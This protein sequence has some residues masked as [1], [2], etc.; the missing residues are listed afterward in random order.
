MSN[1]RNTAKDDFAPMMQK[2][3]NK[4]S[5]ANNGKLPDDLSLLGSYFDPPVDD[6]LLRRYEP[7]DKKSQE[8]SNGVAVIEKMVV[9]PVREGRV[10]IGLHYTSVGSPPAQPK[11]FH[12]PPEL[13]PALKLYQ[14]ENNGRLPKNFSD[15]KAYVTTPEQEAALEKFLFLLKH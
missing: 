1:V 8:W 7:V 15:L 11:M 13:R 4:Y 3:L 9:D 5:E 6:A 12:F 2:A 10:Q 14:S